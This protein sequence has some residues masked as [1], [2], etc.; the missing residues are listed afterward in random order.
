METPDLL[1]LFVRP[2]HRAG[3][4][5]MVTGSLASVHYGEPRLTL[6]VDVVVHVGEGE[7]AAIAGLFPSADFYAPPPEIVATEIARPVR[8]HFNVIH[9]ASGQKADFYPS[10][11]HPYWQWAF[12]H[13]GWSAWATTR[14]G[15]RRRNTSSCGS[16][17][18]F[19]KAAATNTCATFAACCS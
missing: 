13:R 5:Y 3:V 9:F 1:A 16:W 2:L 11:R 14:C 4:R 7:A 10:R 6:D 8:G 15:S 18:F 12:D 17:S 19:A